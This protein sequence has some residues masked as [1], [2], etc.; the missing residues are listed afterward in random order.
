VPWKRLEL[1]TSRMRLA[2]PATNADIS[3]AELA[4]DTEFSADYKDFLNYAAGGEGVIGKD[5][6]VMLWTPSEL[7]HLNDA[8]EVSR[9]APGLLLFGSNGGGEAFAFDLRQP[10]LP[11]VAVPFVG[12]ELDA[13]EPLAET[14]SEFLEKGWEL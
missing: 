4:F 5:T 3:N 9:Y 1:L 6:Y 2:T 13:I 7:K 10:H 11:V 14:F 8:Y 12:M